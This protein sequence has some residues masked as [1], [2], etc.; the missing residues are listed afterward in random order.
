MKQRN[1]SSK[2]LHIKSGS[3]LKLVRKGDLVVVET[4]KNNLKGKV[5]EVNYHKDKTANNLVTVSN[6][7]A[8]SVALRQ[9]FFTPDNGSLYPQ[10]LEDIFGRVSNRKLYE[11]YSGFLKLE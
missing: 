6:S 1:S 10:H 7:G 8:G 11:R 5:Y 3:D 2:I 9:Y 4:G